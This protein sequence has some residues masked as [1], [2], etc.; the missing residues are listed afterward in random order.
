MDIEYNL[1]LC[2]ICLDEGATN[3]IFESTEPDT[4]IFSKLSRCM[5][6]KV[7]SLHYLTT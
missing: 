7:S 3:P 1:N 6:E 4:D 5:K 2:R